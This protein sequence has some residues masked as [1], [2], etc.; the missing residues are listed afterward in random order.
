MVNKIDLPQAEPERVKLEIEEMVGINANDAPLV[1]AKTGEGI[2]ILLEK[3]VNDIPSPEGDPNASLQALIVDS[4][5]DS[6]LGV[7]SLIRIKNGSIKKGQK[8]QIQSNGQCH[9]CLLYTSPS[10]RDAT[11]SRMPSS[12]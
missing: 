2:E 4:W 10:P 6:Y 5:F 12:A 11:L 8:F 7:V 3:L 9:T 1:S